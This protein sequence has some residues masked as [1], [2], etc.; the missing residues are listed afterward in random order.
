MGESPSRAQEPHC[1]SSPL[2]TGLGEGERQERSALLQGS[3]A[4]SRRAPGGPEAPV[5]AGSGECA[6][7][8]FRLAL[9]GT[10][11]LG[12]PLLHRGPQHRMMR[13]WV[14]LGCL[15]PWH[16]PE[17]SASEQS[18]PHPHPKIMES[19]GSGL[20]L[21]FP[22]HLRPRC[23]LG[24]VSPPAT[25]YKPTSQATSARARPGCR[26]RPLLAA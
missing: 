7:P 9:K 18:P 6:S 26:G 17:Q 10:G 22:A 5:G 24:I 16:G 25:L 3:W 14:P 15:S 21:P 2:R 13:T 19:G 11:A 20:W 1:G 12:P 8:R 23:L 4:E